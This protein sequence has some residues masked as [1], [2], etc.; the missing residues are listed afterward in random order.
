MKIDS[1]IYL[2]GHRGLI[3]SAI[4]AKLQSEGFSN[5]ILRTH[6]ECDLIR[7]SNAEEFFCKE[8]PEY[9][10]MA[11]GK[12]GGIKANISYPAQFIY[13][14]ISIQNNIIHSSYLYGIKKL[15]FFGSACSY[16][17]LSP[18]PIK[19][20]YL[21]KGEPEPTNEPYAIAK[22]SGIKMCQAYNRQYGTVYISAMVTNTFGPKDNFNPQDSHVIPA[23]IRKFHNAKAEGEPVVTIWGS[24]KPRREFIYVEDVADASIFLMNHYNDSEVINVCTGSDISIKEL[25]YII[26]DITEYK[27]KVVFDSSMPDGIPRKVL[28]ASKITSLGWKARFSLMEGIEKTYKWYKESERL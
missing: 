17:R 25:A 8:K 9:V 24:G 27:G 14:N 22:I 18:Q 11:V 4:Y 26:R 5:V 2:A 7:Q 6:K 21:L 10:I 19:E 13:E 28:D 23:L 3:G 12:V 20:E 16:P 15:L 1:K